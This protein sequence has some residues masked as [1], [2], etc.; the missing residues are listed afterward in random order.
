MKPSR[1]G[2]SGQDDWEA[3]FTGSQWK[4]D[5]EDHEA[6]WMSG[7][8]AAWEALLASDWAPLRHRV[9]SEL[10]ARKAEQELSRDLGSQF[11]DPRLNQKWLDPEVGT[12]RPV[13]RSWVEQGLLKME[14]SVCGIT[15]NGKKTME[16]HM[17]GRKHLTKLKDF[18]V[19]D[20]GFSSQ[21]AGSEDLV[22][23]R[24]LLANLLDRLPTPPTLVGQ[25]FLAEVLVG[26]GEPEYHCLVCECS[27]LNIQQI[28][29]HLLSVSHRLAAMGHVDPTLY[30]QFSGE[31]APGLWDKAGLARLEQA[32]SKVVVGRKEKD[33]PMVFANPIVFESKKPSLM[34]GIYSLGQKA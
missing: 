26:R 20:G 23:E 31:P 24:S 25:Q 10:Q 33:V 8:L 1:N 5:S 16:S 22:P 15:V 6:Q 4:A 12:E 32:A 9:D 30:H 11:N 14:C 7:H 27:G 28:L 13:F 34:S 17:S 2:D 19:T 3:Y 18:Q 29:P 21:E